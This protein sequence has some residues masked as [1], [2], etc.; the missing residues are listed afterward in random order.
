[1][2]ALF[3]V[4]VALETAAS[5]EKSALIIWLL[6]YPQVQGSGIGHIQPVDSTR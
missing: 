1:M 4:M 6:G 2:S 5:P 3:G